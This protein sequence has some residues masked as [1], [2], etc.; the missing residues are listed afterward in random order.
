MNKKTALC[1]FGNCGWE[2]DKNGDKKNLHPNKCFESVY[3]TIIKNNNID[4]F[5]HSWSKNQQSDIIK[6]LNPIL[7]KI[8]EQKYFYD[9]VDD[10]SAYFKSFID[11]KNVVLEKLRNIDSR[12]YI[13]RAY[14]RWYSTK[15]VIELKNQYEQLNNLK[16]DYVML[17]R[18]DIEFYTDIV[19]ETFNPNI[20]YAG[21][22]SNL[23]YKMHRYLHDSYPELI[24]DVP[25]ISPFNELLFKLYEYFKDIGCGKRIFN[26]QPNVITAISMLLGFNYY[27]LSDTWFFSGNSIM[28]KFSL[29]YNNVGNYN[30]SP[31]ISSY[32][33]LLSII[34]KDNLS[35][36][37]KQFEDYELYRQ[38]RNSE[39]K[40]LIINWLNE[41]L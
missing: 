5:V 2:L 31:H 19:F 29:L 13:N 25:R 1:Y 23:S 8:E 16:Y 41:V 34:D 37:Y 30:P 39:K 4:I 24:K 10:R 18:M 38:G 27:H 36:P 22:P 20:F 6:T 12:D 11:C 26:A 9:Q 3:N 17:L 15:K 33:H 7:Y 35:F 28:N 40:D 14:S 21:D 32:Q